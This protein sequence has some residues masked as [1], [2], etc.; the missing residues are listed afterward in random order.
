MATSNPT[1]S[2]GLTIRLDQIHVPANVRR[3]NAEHVDALAASIALQGMLV[4]IV[5]CPATAEH[6]SA[7]FAHE[8]VAGFH[9]VAAAAKLGLSEVPTVI[10]DSAGEQSDRAIENIACLQLDPASEAEAVRAML[11][12]GFTEDGA[13]QALGWPKARI[14]ARVKLL[15]LPEKARELV[16]AGVIPLSAVDQL[17][18]IGA[19]SPPL[20]D[21][22]IEYIGGDQD[23]HTWVASQLVSDPG[24]VLGNALRESDSKVFA[25]Y[26]QQLPAGA[27]DELRLGPKAGEQLA[28]AEKLHKQVNQYAYGAPAI[29]F[30]E[31]DVDEARAAG[32]LIELD[33]SVPIIVDRPLYRAP[34]SA[35][36]R[37]PSSN[38]G[39]TRSAPRPSARPRA[40][41]ARTSRP[42][43][44]RRR[45]ASTAAGC[46]SWPA[47]RTAPT[48]TSAS[49]C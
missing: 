24:H 3:L 13:A 43:R 23:Q 47:R 44:S 28:E 20:L 7:G 21:L 19:V 33:R 14:T 12:K 18:S 45:G 11:D 31:Q 46:A 37:G 1:A 41:G 15:E 17:R 36:S 30:V 29:R 49:L 5:V 39:P 4:P 42:I 9:R 48:S 8:L 34:P 2:T 38:S 6:A 22:L 27:V 25:A 10:R 26:L 32:V 40:T 35:P 16:G